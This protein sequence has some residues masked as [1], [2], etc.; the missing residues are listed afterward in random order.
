M[1]VSAQLRNRRP[2][3]SFFESSTYLF[4]EFIQEVILKSSGFV[5]W[6]DNENNKKLVT[7]QFAMIPDQVSKFLQDQDIEPL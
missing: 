7:R 1:P 6:R 2:L 4:G 5:C 3:E